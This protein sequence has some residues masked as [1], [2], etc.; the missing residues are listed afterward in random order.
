MRLTVLFLT[1]FLSLQA[2]GWQEDFAAAKALAQEE[3]KPMLVLFMRPN[4]PFCTRLENETLTHPAIQKRIEEGFVPVWIDTQSNPRQVQASGLS[5]RGVPTAVIV[6]N[7]KEQ[8]RMVGFR[9]P[10]GMMGFLS[11]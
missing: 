8:A 1:L 2:S 3:N 6:Q 7:G 9:D 10:M 11:R 5:V 4:C